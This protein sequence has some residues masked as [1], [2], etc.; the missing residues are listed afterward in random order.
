MNIIVLGAGTWGT[1]LAEVLY[2]NGHNVT[3][4][5]YR[6]DFVDKLISTRVHPNLKNHILSKR[7]ITKTAKI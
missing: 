4:W 3:L 7:I 6:K 5:H 1:T 2:D